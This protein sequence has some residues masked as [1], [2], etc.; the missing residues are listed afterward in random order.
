MDIVDKKNLPAGNYE[1]TVTFETK[2][3]ASC[4]VTL[5]VIVGASSEKEY[6]LTITTGTE[7]EFTESDFYN[8][9]FR[10]EKYVVVRNL[11][12]KE[13]RIRVDTSGLKNFEVDDQMAKWAEDY[14]EQDS[15]IVGDRIYQ[16]L[17]DA[18]EPV[19]GIT[20]GAEKTAQSFLVNGSL[21]LNEDENNE[22]LDTAVSITGLFNV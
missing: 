3:G 13:T 14:E 12:K 8:P 15:F 20:N 7:E 19:T 17:A 1:E 22:G 6:D 5:K 4:P 18:V 21:E 16:G 10:V 2:E 9:E 11:G